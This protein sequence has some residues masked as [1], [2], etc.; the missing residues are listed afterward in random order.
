MLAL[1]EEVF[2]RVALRFSRLVKIGVCSVKS[3]ETSYGLEMWN[4]NR[5]MIRKT[6]FYVKSVIWTYWA[7]K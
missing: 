2:V 5:E 4:R 1:A 6:T 3:F 7:I